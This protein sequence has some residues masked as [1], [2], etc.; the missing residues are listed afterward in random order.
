MVFYFIL[1]S[2][3]LFADALGIIG[4]LCEVFQNR[5]K[6]VIN[7]EVIKYIL[8]KLRYE[9]TRKYDKLCQWAQEVN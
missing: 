8:D 3:T 1:N 5:M 9:K 7:I 4:D 6:D 2:K